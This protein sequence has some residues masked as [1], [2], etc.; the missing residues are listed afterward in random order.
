MTG[1]ITADTSRPPQLSPISWLIPGSVGT[2]G[3]T[4]VGANGL[5]CVMPYTGSI[6]S[7]TMTINA[8]ATGDGTLQLGLV[9]QTTSFG[10]NPTIDLVTTAL[11]ST[12]VISDAAFVAGDVVVA[13][14]FSDSNTFGPS[15]LWLT[16]WC[17]R[18]A[19]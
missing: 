12:A 4:P 17:L 11:T 16:A 3:A 2:G 10:T 19:T 7:L 5:T 15:D 8:T 13:T 1:W 9:N 6:A 18:E 14:I